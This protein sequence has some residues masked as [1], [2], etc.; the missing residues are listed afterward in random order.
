MDEFPPAA[1]E[2]AAQFVLPRDVSDILWR[3]LV[4]FPS[5]FYVCVDSVFAGKND[6]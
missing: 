4:V 5:F 3:P 2:L 6:S 1:E